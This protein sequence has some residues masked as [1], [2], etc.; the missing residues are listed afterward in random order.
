MEGGDTMKRHILNVIFYCALCII[1]CALLSSCRHKGF[2]YDHPHGDIFVEVEYDD[3]N[4]PD[5]IAYLNQYVNATRL[6]AFNNETGEA[7]LASDIARK[8][9]RLLLDANVYNF[10]ALNAGTQSISFN[11]QE[12]F[13]GYLATTRQCTILEPFYASRAEGSDLDLGNGEPVVIEAEPLWAV[14]A[15]AVRCN[16]GDT[17]RLKAIPLHCRYTYEMR[18]VEG[19]KG[20][21]RVSS[22]ITGMSSGATLSSTTLVDNPVTVAV[23]AYISYDQKSIVGHF[24]CFGH[25]PRIDARHRMGLFVEMENGMKYKLIQGE[26]FDVT[27]QVVNA[28]NRRRVHIIIDGVKIPTSTDADAGFDITVGPWGDGE[29]LDI[30]F[31]F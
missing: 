5:D 19:L 1:N 4:D 23:P 9:N 6:M 14:G 29:N 21:T 7:I 17:V 27:K 31:N 28:P 30:D 13:Y 20:V 15:E 25:N 10:V 26:H 3:D 16:L 2:C 22:F 12:G 18:N 11:E 8:T 24:M